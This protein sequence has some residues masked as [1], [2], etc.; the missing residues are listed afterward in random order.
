MKDYG[1]SV[2]AH[3]VVFHSDRRVRIRERDGS[4]TIFKSK[5]RPPRHRDSIVGF[6]RA[7]Q[8]HLEF[9]VANVGDCFRTIITLTYHALVEEGEDEA[10]R[11]A[12]VAARSKRDLNR[13]LSCLRA[14]LG[15][16]LWVQEF[17]ERGVVHYHVLC[18]GVV[19]EERVSLV[20]C[21][22]TGQ[23]DDVDAVRYAVRV[24]P[25]REEGAARAYVGSYLG[26]ARQKAL[27]PG[28]AGSGRWWGRSRSLRVV[29]LVEIIACER[30][31]AASMRSG[32]RIVRSL[33]RW[34]S[35]ELGWKFRGGRFVSWGDE[36]TSRMAKAAHELIA[37]YGMPRRRSE[38]LAEMG[39]EGVVEGGNHGM[40]A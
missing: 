27:P 11:N 3:G 8:R 7:S 29:A 20:W 21:R 25:I 4:V 31:D 6:S 40:A 32:V 34:L 10:Y 5:G 9:I 16:Y 38:L 28:V 22:A 13:F 37:F 39:W 19:D 23:L 1:I 14:E 17:Q 35:R 2:F 26:K 15:S 12:R 36:L 24:E 18:G 33:R 30:G